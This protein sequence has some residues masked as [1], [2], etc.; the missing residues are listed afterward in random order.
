MQLGTPVEAVLFDFNGTLSDDEPLLA[1]LF[2][3]LARERL[4]LSVSREWYFDELVG[5]SDPEIVD[6]LIGLLNGNPLDQAM[7]H[8]LLAEKVKRY[9]EAV[10]LAPRISAEA[11]AFVREVASLVPVAV[12]SGAIHE[13]VDAALMAA[14]LAGIFGA[15]VCGDDV[16]CGKPN[17]EGYE[18]ALAALGVNDATRAV[19]FEDSVAGLAAAHTLGA[20]TVKVGAGQARASEGLYQV[21]MNCL[22]LEEGAWLLERL[23]EGP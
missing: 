4:G 19:V 5:L 3:A 16:V 23:R 13:E 11:V 1:D 17:P 6:R 9:Q 7:W 10:R 12:V 21:A 20:F 2:I 8:A 14:G 15:V 22:S 18:T